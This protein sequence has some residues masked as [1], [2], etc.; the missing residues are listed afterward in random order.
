MLLFP[1]KDWEYVNRIANRLLV[2]AQR[3]KEFVERGDFTG[4]WLSSVSINTLAGYLNDF[5]EEKRR[6]GWLR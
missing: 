6:Q 2:E 3:L 4:V 1:V 5:V